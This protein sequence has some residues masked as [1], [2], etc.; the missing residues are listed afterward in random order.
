[1]WCIAS[2]RPSIREFY[3]AVA[4]RIDL[5]IHRGYEIFANNYVALDM[6]NGTTE[7]SS[8]YTEE[9]KSH[10]VAYL[11]QRIAMVDLADKDEAFL[12]ER[13]LTMYANPLINHLNALAAK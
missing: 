4:Q 10:F 13:L 5:N 11:S 3:K 2:L 12:R 7:H 1:M 8:H 9:E 6:L